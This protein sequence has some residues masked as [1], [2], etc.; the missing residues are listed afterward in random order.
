MSLDRRAALDELYAAIGELRTRL[1]GARQLADATGRSGWPD[2][3]VYLFFEAGEYREDGVTPRVT[4]VGTHALTA[5]SKTRLW[6]RL[7]QH[8]GSVGGTN[9]GGGNHRGSV[10]RLHVG[11]ALI[12][13]DGWPGAAPTWGR[14]SNASR[15]VRNQEAELERAVSRFIGAMPVL[16]LDVPER[17]DRRVI[18][19][20][21]IALLSDAGRESLDPP[22]QTWL[23]HHANRDA[24]RRSGLWNVNHIY[25]AP[26][27]AAV[28]E[29]CRHVLR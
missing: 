2:Q 12:A 21:L 17:A 23:G 14:G 10:F 29:F 25:E 13:R 22:S 15:E 24:I 3:G 11:T 16:W 7:A 18:E 27:R 26:N 28:D 19:A 9:P 20:G 8:R 5:T 6:T 4:R 1:D